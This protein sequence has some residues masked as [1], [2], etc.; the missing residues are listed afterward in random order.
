MHRA[1]DGPSTTTPA[2]PPEPR[3]GSRPALKPAEGSRLPPQSAG[4]DQRAKRPAV[5]CALGGRPH[6]TCGPAAGRAP[7]GCGV[8]LAGAACAQTR[9]DQGPR[10]WCPCAQARDGGPASACTCGPRRRVR[11]ERRP[12]SPFSL[13]RPV[14]KC[15]RAPG[16][17]TEGNVQSTA[18][19]GEAPTFFSNGDFLPTVTATRSTV[20]PERFG[21]SG[22]E[23]ARGKE[24]DG[25][26]APGHSAGPRGVRER[27]GHPRHSSRR[28]TGQA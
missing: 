5:S 8:R 19:A 14:D 23:Q 26:R 17:H 4:N 10:H 11:N 6:G 24:M 25:R 1:E 3:G 2:W 12:P 9:P 13:I 15:L 18:F 20:K 22:G 28:S 21:H 7:T 27:D 16:V